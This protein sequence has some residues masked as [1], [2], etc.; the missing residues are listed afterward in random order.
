[1]WKERRR[2][3][4]DNEFIVDKNIDLL[5]VVWIWYIKS[6]LDD[7]VMDWILSHFK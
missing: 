6:I 7:K 4:D 5:M 3:L 2:G 1:M